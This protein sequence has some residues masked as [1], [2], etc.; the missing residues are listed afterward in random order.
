MRARLVVPFLVAGLVSSCSG[1]ETGSPATSAAGADPSV[2]GQLTVFAASSLTDAFTEIG[3]TFRSAHPEVEVTFSFGGSSDLVAQLAEGAPADVLATAD[4]STMATAVEAGSVVGLP[5]V[6]ATNTFGIIVE[7]GNPK[8]V[9][10][11]ADLADPSLLVV[12]C[13]ETVPCG[14][15]AAAV[16]A[17][18]GVTVNAVSFE[19]KV[20]GVVTKVASGEAD[21]GIVF[22]TDIAAAGDAASGVEIPAEVNVTNSYALAVTS[23]APNTAA[24]EAFASFVTSAQ[25]R[26]I[27]EAYGFGLP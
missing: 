9:G 18:V 27:L 7:A 22:V 26:S 16:L 21:A 19:Q 1:A 14:K 12:L 13:A 11:V 8:G 24:A 6:F 23:E 20:K 3:D 17:N 2:S 5:A 4:E 15:G 25:G 10:G